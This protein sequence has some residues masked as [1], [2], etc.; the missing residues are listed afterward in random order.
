MYIRKPPSLFARQSSQENSTAQ[1]LNNKFIMSKV[2]L[3]LFC[4]SALIAFK[5]IIP[6]EA[7][8]IA[9]FCLANK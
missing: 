7:A 9:T 2:T 5:G 6:G 3:F 4:V 1:Q 8:E